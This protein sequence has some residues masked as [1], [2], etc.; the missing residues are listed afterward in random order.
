MEIQLNCLR[1]RV[2]SG[3][4][5]ER[6]ARKLGANDT[7]Q[8]KSDTHEKL[9]LKKGKN[10]NGLNTL[11]E[12]PYALGNL[13]CEQPSSSVCVIHDSRFKFLVRGR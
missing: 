2:E 8:H 3:H 4:T 11:H 10:R 7:Q 1:M 6:K 12:F 5:S 13:V 9:E